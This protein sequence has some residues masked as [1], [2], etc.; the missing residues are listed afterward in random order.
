MHD[1]KN[2][3]DPIDHMVDLETLREMEEVLPMTVYERNSLRSW[4]YRGNDPERNPWGYCDTDGWPKNYLNAYRYHHGYD[5]KIRQI[6]IE[7]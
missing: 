7:E 4:V 5:Y 3:R 1:Y 6:I 2:D